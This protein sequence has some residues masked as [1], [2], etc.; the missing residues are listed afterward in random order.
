MNFK[1]YLNFNNED[2]RKVDLLIINQTMQIVLIYTFI[3]WTS[4]INFYHC[5]K[6]GKVLS[7]R[8]YEKDIISPKFLTLLNKLGTSRRRV[9]IIFY[10]QYSTRWER[11][12]LD[13]DYGDRNIH[14]VINSPVIVAN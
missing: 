1:Q 6:T 5:L 11:V 3:S 4:G 9:S 7:Q 12:C 2:E 10:R 13:E 14:G 8:E